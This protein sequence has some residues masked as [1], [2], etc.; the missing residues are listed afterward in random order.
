[1][2]T[3]RVAGYPPTISPL[4]PA[5]VPPLNQALN[6]GDKVVY[7]RSRRQGWR[8]S[9]TSPTFFDTGMTLAVGIAGEKTL[10]ITRRK[11]FMSLGRR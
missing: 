4:A 6:R 8:E 11:N 2:R 1:M 9:L 10:S 5:I 7:S 3:T